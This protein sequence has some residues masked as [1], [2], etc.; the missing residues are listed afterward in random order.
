MIKETSPQR[1]E[2]TEISTACLDGADCFILTH[3]TSIGSNNILATTYLAKAI[4]EAENVF[5]YDQAYINVRDEL[6]GLGQKANNLDMLA[7]TGCNIAYEQRENVDLFI[8]LTNDG[9]IARHLA[10]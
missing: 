4:A 9:L 6:K 2:L 3:E 5:D 10:K 1:P 8:C 7:S